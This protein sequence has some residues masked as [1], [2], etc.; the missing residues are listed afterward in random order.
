MTDTASDLEAAM[1]AAVADGDYEKAGQ[2]GIAAGFSLEFVPVILANLAI[3]VGR[4]ED[5]ISFLPSLQPAAEP[6]PDAQ[7]KDAEPSVGPSALGAA[8]TDEEAEEERQRGWADER[9]R[10]EQ[11]WRERQEKEAA[12]AASTKEW[13]QRQ[14][15]AY[16]SAK[17]AQAKLIE[18]TS[19]PP[20]LRSFQHFPLASGLALSFLQK[21][22]LSSLGVS[23][24]SL[25]GERTFGHQRWRIHRRVSGNGLGVGGF[26]S[27]TMLS[28]TWSTYS[29]NGA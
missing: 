22:Q 28:A 26:N 29:L 12:D 5:A 15:E 18:S 16:D 7:P 3:E 27:M 11:A 4:T 23:L 13:V 1:K 24:S 2:L 21:S 20:T 9:V 6:G 19:E 14:A 17:E 25:I 10:R 8:R